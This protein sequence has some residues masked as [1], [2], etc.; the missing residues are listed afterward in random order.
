MIRNIFGYIKKLFWILSR[1]QKVYCVLLFFIVILCAGVQ[2]LSVYVIVPLVSAMTDKEAF[3]DTEIVNFISKAFNINDFNVL[4]LTFCMLIAFIYLIKE[5]LIIF[6]MWL[7][8]KVSQKIERDLSK[9]VFE[10]YMAREYDFFLGYGTSKVLRDVEKDPG[11]VYN[12][13]MGFINILAELITAFLLLM[14]IVFSDYEM[15]ICLAGLTIISLYILIYR[16]KRGLLKNGEESRVLSAERHKI[17]LEAVEGVKEVHV[18]KKQRN[19]VDSYFNQFVKSQKPLAFYSLASTSPTAIIEGIFVIGIVLFMGVKAFYDSLFWSKLPLLA[20]FFVAA[21][22]LLPSMGRITSNINTIQFYVPSL[23]SVYENIQL[24]RS[25]GLNKAK[26]S[27]S[28]SGE[29]LLFNNRLDINGV[30]YCYHDSGK[31]VLRD[32]NLSIFKGESVGIIGQSGAG[33]STLADLILGL[34][35]PQKGKIT[36]DGINIL[37][38]PFEYS[39]V[40]GYVPQTVYLIDGTIR[41]NVAFGVEPEKIDD[42]CVIEALKKARLYEFVAGSEKGLD[43][44]VGERGVR[45]SGGQ[46]QRLAIAR[47]LYRK[48]QILVLDEATSALDN[49][50]EKAVMEQVEEMQGTITLIIIAHRLSTISKCDKIYEI[51]DGK[52]ELSTIE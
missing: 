6:Q 9:E 21:V 43:T 50:T 30:T 8:I 11:S 1:T 5:T 46:K 42:D 45:F 13:L 26:L 32:L 16:L 51:I 29:G 49:E 10:S 25:L 23:N 37:D 48:P 14:Y 27:M 4:F 7:S 39:R 47:A 12:I 17:L 40:I 24:I 18:M 35:I 33:K 44:I 38:I 19:F 41:E 28:D 31:E 22:R 3:F 36:I 20:S 15:A 34:H 2:T 52:A